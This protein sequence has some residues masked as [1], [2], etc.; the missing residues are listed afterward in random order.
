M[1][2]TTNKT[3]YLNGNS[4]TGDK[5]LANFNAS[6]SEDGQISINETV[7]DKDSITT[8]DKD[9]DDFRALAKS[10]LNVDDKGS[11]SLNG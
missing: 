11:D 10:V 6:L 4:K 1:A 2:L 5:I 3:I 9:F 7:M 8:V